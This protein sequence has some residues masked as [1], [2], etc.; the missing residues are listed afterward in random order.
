VS[1]GYF[2]MC[3]GAFV[4][5]GI[6]V[7]DTLS[8]ERQA[9]E[10]PAVFQRTSPE[11]AEKYKRQAHKIVDRMPNFSGDFESLSGT[12][13]VHIPQNYSITYERGLSQW[14]GGVQLYVTVAFDPRSGAQWGPEY[15]LA[16]AVSGPSAYGIALDDWADPRAFDYDDN[17]EVKE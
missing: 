4:L 13:W 12:G 16:P 10:T 7:L 8:K 3:I 14:W 17:Q 15:H 9:H 5:G 6:L 1:I 2:L 11:T